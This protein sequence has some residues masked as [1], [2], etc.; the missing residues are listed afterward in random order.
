MPPPPTSSGY[1]HD[2]PEDASR[3]TFIKTAQRLGLPLQEVGELLS[4]RYR[5]APR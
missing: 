1:R 4:L 2:S 3:L 5:R